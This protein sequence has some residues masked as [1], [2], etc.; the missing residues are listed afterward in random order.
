MVLTGCQCTEIGRRSGIKRKTFLN[1]NCDFC[2][3]QMSTVQSKV[4]AGKSNWGQADVF[5]IRKRMLSQL[6]CIIFKVGRWGGVEK[7]RSCFK[8]GDQSASAVS[9]TNCTST[10]SK[11][12]PLDKIKT[13][14]SVL[15]CGWRYATVRP[16]YAKHSRGR[17]KKTAFP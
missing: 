10:Q 12:A 16:N 14:P 1:L 6:Q 15:T 2:L 3:I 9:Q 4:A 17:K 7:Q 8:L 5:H 11:I 13:S